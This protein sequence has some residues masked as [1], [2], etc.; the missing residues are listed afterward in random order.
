MTGPP[1]TVTADDPE[2]RDPG[3]LRWLRQHDVVPS[4][5][6]EVTISGGDMLVTQYV[7]DRHGKI[8]MEDRNTPK[9][10]TFH[11]TVWWK[12]PL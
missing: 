5:T 4:D 12:P 8:V 7:R 1:V 10:T 2:A 9:L 3:W 11:R 6:K